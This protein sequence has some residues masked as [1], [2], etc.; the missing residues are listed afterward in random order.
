[1]IIFKIVYIIFELCMVIDCNKLVL[2]L[3]ELKERKKEREIFLDE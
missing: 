1:M 3:I 2:I